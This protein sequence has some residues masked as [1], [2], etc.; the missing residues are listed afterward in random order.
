LG[1]DL[2]DIVTR[3]KSSLDEFSGKTFAVDAYNA[4]Y[5]FLAI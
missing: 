1:V 4:L 5:Q 3:T 2:G